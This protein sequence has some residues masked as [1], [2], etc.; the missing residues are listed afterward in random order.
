MSILT[1]KKDHSWVKW[2]INEE[3]R[4]TVEPIAR[5]FGM[6]I[7][8]FLKLFTLD[9]LPAQLPSRDFSEDQ[10]EDV[11]LNLNFVALSCSKAWP[12]IWRA[13]KVEGLSVEE[14]LTEAIMDNV[15]GAEEDMVLSP[16]T[17]EL[18][19]SAFELRDFIIEEEEHPETCED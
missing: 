17:G 10:D 7:E 16:R 12:R 14:F 19:A 13:A 15:R 18:I 1:V 5:E 9:K 8:R 2:E 11:D 6:S 4:K 3:C